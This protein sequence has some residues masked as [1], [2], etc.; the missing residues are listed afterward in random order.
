MKKAA[1]RHL[2]MQTSQHSLEIQQISRIW[3]RNLLNQ[4][5]HKSFISTTIHNKAATSDSMTHSLEVVLPLPNQNNEAYLRFRDPVATKITEALSFVSARFCQNSSFYFITVI[6]SCTSV[7]WNLCLLTV[8]WE[9]MARKLVV[10]LHDLYIHYKYDL[11]LL[12]N[13]ITVCCS[14]MADVCSRQ[15]WPRV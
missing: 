2:T 4:Q 12:K 13:S 5:L 15:N 8:K 3:F 7:W 11:I 1:W 14:Q 6:S 9:R 10:M